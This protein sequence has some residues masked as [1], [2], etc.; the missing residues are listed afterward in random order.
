MRLLQKNGTELLVHPVSIKELK[1]DENNERKNI[2]LSKVSSYPP[3]DEPPSYDSDIDFINRIYPLANEHDVNDASIIYSVYRN[4]VTFLITEDRK[5]L[6]KAQR[7][8]LEERC[9]SVNGALRYFKELFKDISLTLPPAFEKKKLYNLDY[10]DPILDKLRDS[11][12]GF[13]D[14]WEKICQEGRNAYVSYNQDRSLGA[15]MIYKEEDEAI[16]SEPPLPEKKR[17]KL[18]T[19]IVT[20]TGNKIGEFFIKIAIEITMKKGLDEIYLTHFEEENDLLIP[21]ITSFG[22]KKVAIKNTHGKEESIYLKKLKFDPIQTFTHPFEISYC[23]YPS[24]YDGDKV[25]KYLIPIRGEYHEKIF[26]DQPRQTGLFEFSGE[27]VVEGNT[28][29]KAYLCHAS[30]KSMK[31]GDIILFYRSVD[32]KEILTLGVIETVH[33]GFFEPEDVVK[34]VGKRTVYSRE[35]IDEMSIKNLT[36]ILFRHHFHLK[37]PLGLDQLRNMRIISEA[38]QSIMRITHEKYQRIKQEGGID[39]SYTVN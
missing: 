37:N 5:L 4:A 34:I 36:I 21:L 16:K 10:D 29:K 15:L 39:E 6:S 11:Y 18:A 7:A 9:F 2:V 20:N 27:H 13:K 23:C 32:K 24:F 3:L 35:E 22:F 8:G 31:K 33:Q 12:D 19:M 38:P 26:I 1:K 25:N 30:I 28:M 14:W 17:I